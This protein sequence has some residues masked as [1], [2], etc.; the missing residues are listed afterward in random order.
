[1][2]AVR[3]ARLSLR[4]RAIV[5]PSPLIRTIAIPS[6]ASSSLTI[7][8]SPSVPTIRAFSSTPTTYKKKDKSG[9]KSDSKNSASE[10]SSSGGA[11]DHSAA[12]D[13]LDA[14]MQKAVDRLSEE[15]QKLKAGR[16]DPSFLENLEVLLDKTTNDKAMVKDIAH[17]VVKG[18]GL[19]VT[20]YEVPNVKKIASAIQLANLNVTPVID[21][22]NPQLINVPLPAPTKESR[23]ASAAQ[24][25]KIGLKA[26]EVIQAARAVIHK[27]LQTTKKTHP[28]D[29]RK[30]EKKMEDAVKKKK[31]EAEALCKKVEKEIMSG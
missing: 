12:F 2:S 4:A 15:L 10:S 21:T 23:M 13:K 1:M 8:S 25:P 14:D 5:L 26:V 27:K 9:G 11:E 7:A 19:A 22:K 16:A 17:V 3:V 18:R 30:N 24:V 29:Y 28:D 20:V 31:S 6:Y